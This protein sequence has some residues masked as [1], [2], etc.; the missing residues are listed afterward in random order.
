MENEIRIESF[1]KYIEKVREDY[2]PRHPILFR[3]QAD[4]DWALV[5]RAGREKFKATN[6]KALF[7][8]WKRRAVE[9]LEKT[10]DPKDDVSWL[11]IAQHHGLATRL[12]DWT[13]NPLVALFFAA[14]E[15][16][17]KDAAVF[18]YYRED[19]RSYENIEEELF[20]LCTEEY[21]QIIRPPSIVPRIARQAGVFTVHF[22]FEKAFGC[23]ESLME[24]DAL[25]KIVIPASL[26]KHALN[27]LDFFGINDSTLFPDID[28]LSRYYN[29]KAENKNFI[30]DPSL[31]DEDT[32]SYGVI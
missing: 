20:G 18:C 10:P 16:P 8:E 32:L 30:R 12:L 22:S 26:K 1:D 23:P 9:C 31:D 6:D 14:V 4:R 28:G 17:E 29:W 5:P 15:Y 11:V 27:M 19:L 25:E 13:T 7:Y 3:G 24:G 2:D 21:P